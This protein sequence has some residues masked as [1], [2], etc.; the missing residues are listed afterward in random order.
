M[1]Q[2]KHKFKN[3]LKI[4]RLPFLIIAVSLLLAAAICILG[5]RERFFPYK[6]VVIKIE[7]TGERDPASQGKEITVVNALNNGEQMDLS[8]ANMVGR[9]AEEE[10]AYTNRGV[11]KGNF[12]EFKAEHVQ[13]LL[14]HFKKSGSGGI[15]QI[16]LNGDPIQRINLYGTE[17]LEYEWEYT[18]TWSF[19]LL[20]ELPLFLAVFLILAGAAGGFCLIRARLRQQ[21]GGW[22]A[23]WT[24]KEIG[25]AV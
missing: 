20:N 17:G 9:W 1:Q 16:Y 2:T 8:G 10:G 14:L 15:L 13:N 4:K 5:F 19:A 11:I 12:L 7:S 3:K 18:G 22:K 23:F 21:E 6:D 24:R 25:E